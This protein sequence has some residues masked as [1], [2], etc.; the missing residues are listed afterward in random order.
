MCI[1][2]YAYLLISDISSNSYLTSQM[3]AIKEKHD[4]FQELLRTVDTTSNQEFKEIRKCKDSHVA[5]F[6]FN[7]FI[8]AI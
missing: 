6:E 4:R 3:E 7:I 2:H 5:F 8:Y 1:H